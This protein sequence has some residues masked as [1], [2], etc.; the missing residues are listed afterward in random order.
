[1]KKITDTQLKILYFRW[2]MGYS[3]RKT[4]KILGKTGGT[5]RIGEHRALKK[6]IYEY[7][8]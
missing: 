6:L 4:A 8:N 7:Y 5:I 1:M 2:Y 3:V